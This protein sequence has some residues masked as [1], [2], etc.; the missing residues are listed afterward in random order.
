MSVSNV[1]A[2][3]QQFTIQDPQSVVLTSPNSGTYTYLQDISIQWTKNNFT[4]NIDLYWTTSTTF[5]TSN[6]ITTNF[7]SHP[8]TWD[9]PSSLAGTSIYIWVRKTGDSTVKD[10]SNSSISITGVTISRTIAE[11]IT[12][13]DSWSKTTGLWK[14]LRTISEG[15]TT[16]DSWS[17]TTRVWKFLRTI[18]E[19]ITSSDSWSKAS[20][21]WIHIRTI[22]EPMPVSDTDSA[23][24]RLWI[25][26]R[27]IAESLSASDT[28]SATSRLW[29]KLRTITESMTVS[30]TDSSVSRLWK[31]IRT[32]ADTLNPIDTASEGHLRLIDEVLAIT[33]T[34]EK[35]IQQAGTAYVL[36]S[37]NGDESF[38]ALYRTGWIMPNNIGKNSI[39]RRINLDYLSESAI[40][41][42]IF[43]DDDIITPFVTK[44]LPSSSTPTHG[45]IR[46]GTRVK[47]FLI[48]IETTQSSNDN[49]RIERIEIEV[50]D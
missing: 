34:W 15:I 12:T 50:D 20:R 10:R 8:Y 17:K 3:S 46:L 44:T 19:G 40:T 36:D 41:L 27:A 4:D 11:P 29:K 47:Y 43:K 22:A 31:K 7:N 33:D 26:I 28:D 23:T 5:S 45:S 16:S 14:I 35:S 1:S 39:I 48:S 32:I 2:T 42:K 13:S 18:A 21:K 24:S 30:E 37:S 38:S 49:V 25:K 9:V 6:V